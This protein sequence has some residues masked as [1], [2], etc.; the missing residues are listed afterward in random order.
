MHA[1]RQTN[2]VVYNIQGTCWACCL[3]VCWTP[4]FVIHITF[5]M[6]NIENISFL[7]EF[8]EQLLIRFILNFMTPELNKICKLKFEFYKI[9]CKSYFILL[10]MQTIFL[11]TNF[12]NFTIVITEIYG[13]FLLFF[14]YFRKILYKLSLVYYSLLH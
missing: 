11:S 10:L 6:K 7:C 14:F 4:S 5:H 9:V 3:Y 12:L 2:H 13:I 1:Y 8:Y